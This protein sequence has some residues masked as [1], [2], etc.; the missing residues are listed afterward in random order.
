MANKV[1][2]RQINL[3]KRQTAWESLRL[4]LL[5]SKGA[6]IALLQEPYLLKG[7]KMP[8]IKG[9]QTVYDSESRSRPRAVILVHNSLEFDTIP[10][11]T[12]PDIVSIRTG[13]IS[14]VIT[15]AYMDSELKG[16]IC[17][18]LQAVIDYAAHSNSRVI[19][20]GD[21]NAHSPVWGSNS[22]NPRGAKVE[23]F[24]KIGRAHV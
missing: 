19:I 12:G 20:G 18:P 6:T 17:A 24:I 2:I 4:D 15:S 16:D 14:N 11:L 23:D 9:Y 5:N 22:T 8:F 7:F 10:A 3:A 13:K 21:F 1:E